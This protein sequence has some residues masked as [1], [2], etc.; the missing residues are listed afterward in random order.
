[1]G[2]FGEHQ[3]SN[4]CKTIMVSGQVPLCTDPLI[5]IWSLVIQHCSGTEAWSRGTHPCNP[6]TGEDE[7][8][9]KL[10]ASLDYI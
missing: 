2:D 8:G 1:M 6:S 4:H 5:D 9:G 10:E 3:H 7:A